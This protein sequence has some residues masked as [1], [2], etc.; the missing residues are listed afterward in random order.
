MNL[1]CV[2]VFCSCL[3]EHHCINIFHPP[4][5]PGDYSYSL[6]RAC[7]FNSFLVSAAVIKW[8]WT[9]LSRCMCFCLSGMTI[10]S[11]LANHV[12]CQLY[13]LLRLHHHTCM[14]VMLGPKHTTELQPQIY[15]RAFACSRTTLILVELQVTNAYSQTIFLYL[16]VFLY[17]NII[18]LL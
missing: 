15:K 1:L 18:V 10:G 9:F 12:V 3:V 2:W 4:P 6:W 17:T 14:L 7:V 8:H 11:R 13:V 5:L 16:T